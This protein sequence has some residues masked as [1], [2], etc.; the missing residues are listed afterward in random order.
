[1]NK[2]TIKVIS[3]V[4]IIDL[5]LN[6]FV[7]PAQTALAANKTAD[8]QIVISYEDGTT[9]VIP[10]EPS[11]SPEPSEQPEEPLEP[12]PTIVPEPSTEPSQSPSE[13]PVVSGTPTEETIEWPV[14][15]ALQSLLDENGFLTDEA[16]SKL[17]LLPSEEE[18]YTEVTDNNDGSHTM[19]LFTEPIKF[20]NE[21][22]E[23]ELIDNS[24]VAV[25]PQVDTEHEYKNAASDVEVLLS[26]DLEEDNAIEM[27]LEDYSIA[28]KPLE[29]VKKD[30]ENKKD[31]NFVVADKS[32]KEST[33]ENKKEEK[34]DKKDKDKKDKGQTQE[35][36]KSEKVKDEVFDETKEYETIEYT[37]TFNENTDIQITPT[38]TGLKE[39]I[40]FNE[41]P[42]EKKFSYELKVEK[43]VPLL[44]ED[45]NLYFIDLEKGLLVA[46]MA[47][48]SMHDSKEEFSESYDIKVKLEQIDEN[49]YKYTLIPSRVFLESETTVYPVV[50]DPSVVATTGLIADS[51]TTSRYSNNNYVNDTDLKVGYGSDLYISRGLVRITS[52]PGQVWGNTIISAYYCAYQNYSG[53]STPTIQLAKITNDWDPNNVRWNNQPGVG[54]VYSELN[55]TGIQWYT[56]DVTSLV[57]S[58]YAD[59][60]NNFGMYVK[61]SNEGS[62]KYKRFSSDNNP[63]NK[64][65]FVINYEDFSPPPTPSNFRVE[66]YSYPS[67]TGSIT[68][69]WSPVADNG[70]AGVHHYQT[71]IWYNGSWSYPDAYTT[72]YTYNNCP[73]NSTYHFAVRAIDT[74][75]NIAENWAYVWNFVSP[76]KTGPSAPSGFSISV[77]NPVNVNGVIWTNDT[78]PTINWSGFWDE[79]NHFDRVEY[80]INNGEWKNKG[81]HAVAGSFSIN[82][83]ELSS[84]G[85]YLIRVRGMDTS[86]NQGTPSGYLEYNKD[87]T[88]PSAELILGAGNLNGIESV[89]ANITDGTGSG[90]ANWVLDYGEGNPAIIYDPN[91]VL[92]SSNT[93]VNGKIFEWDTTQLE[94]NKNYTLRLRAYDK[95]GNPNSATP[96]PIQIR[97]K[98]TGSE[99]VSPQLQIDQPMGFGSDGYQPDIDDID[100][101]MIASPFTEVLFQKLNDGGKEGLDPGKLYVNNKLHDTEAPND[102]LSFNAA[103]YENGKWVYP[104]GSIVFMYTQAKD[105]QN[106]ELYSTGTQIALQIADKFENADKID[107]S[108]IN[109]VECINNDYY[110]LAKTNGIFDSSGSFESIKKQ[111][112][113]DISYIDLT[114][115][116]TVPTGA[117]V[118][119]QV[120]VDGGL[121][122]QAISPVSTDGGIT[123]ILANRKYFVTDPV[124]D[125]VKIK[126]LLTKSASNQSPTISSWSI[127]VRYTTYAN[128]LLIDNSFPK[129]A[130]GMTN[131][132]NTFHNEDI[133]CIELAGNLPEGTIG[134]VYSTVRVTSNDVTKACLEVEQNVPEGTGIS[135]YISTQGGA[136]NTW[137]ELAPN[138]QWTN[139]TNSG[140]E[141]VLA[142]RLTGSGTNSPQLL[143]WKLG[144]EEK[145]AGSP[146]MVKL[147]DEPWNLSTLTDVT[148]RTLL[149]WEASTTEGVTYNVYRSA[150][151]Y[152]VPSDE[153]KVAEGITET[154]W[155][156]PYVDFDDDPYGKTF[157]YK[158][159]AVKMIGDTGNEHA[160]ESLPSNEERAIV[161]DKDEIEKYLGLQNYWSYTGFSTGSGTG[162]VNVANGNMSYITTDIVVSDPFFATVMRRTFNSIATTKT[163]LGYSWDFSFNTCLLRENNSDGSLKAMILKD[164]DGSFHYFAYENGS[165][166]SAK[167][168][169]M[170]LTLNEGLKEYQIKRKDNIVY[171]FDA[172]SLKLKSFSDNNGNQLMFTY[173]VRGNLV[174]VENTVGEKVELTY[175]VL[176]E[177]PEDPDYT[178]ENADYVYVNWHPDL[179][180]TVTWTESG[181]DD[182]VSITYH[183]DYNDDND[184]LQR[185]YTTVEQNTTYEEVFSY[186]AAGQL[187]AI[188]DPEDRVTG[189]SYGAGD[190]IASIT[191]ASGE[192]YNYTYTLNGD[193]KPVSTSVTNPKNVSISYSYDAD[194]LV[195]TK[196]DALGHSINYTYGHT[197]DDD[198][199]VT[200][201]S[202]LNS[203]NGGAPQTISYSYSYVNG[204][205][206]SITAPDGTV[207]D[208][209]TYNSFNKPASVTVSKGSDSAT[210]NYSYDTAGN[211]TVSTDPEDKETINTYGTVNGHA[212]YLTQVQGDFGKQT[213]Y[214]Y[215]TKGRVTEVKEYDNGTFKR[216]AA[217]YDYDY[218]PDY[219]ADGY[220]MS[221]VTTDAMGNSVSSYYDMLGRTVKKVYPDNPDNTADPDVYER[222]SYD[223]VGNVTWMRDS[224]GFETYYHYD[225]MYRMTQ[226]DYADGSHN[227]VNYTGKWNSDG[228]ATTGDSNGNDADRIV[229]TDGTGLQSIEYYDMAG[230]LVKTSVSGASGELV[231]ATYQYDSIGNCT[232]VT[233]SAGRVSQAQYNVVGQKTKTIVDPTG[234]N[235]QTTYLYDFLGNQ[236]SVTDGE[237]NTTSYDYDNDSRLKSVTQTL[238]GNALTTSY[239]YDTPE[240]GVIKNRVTNANGQVSETWFDNMGRK[241]KDYNIGNTGD[242]TVMQTSYTYN[243]NNQPDIVTRNDST[244]EKYT[245]NAFGNVKR[246]DYYEAAESTTGNSDDFVEYKYNNSG[247]VTEESVTRA[248][249]THVTVYVYDSMGRLRQMRQGT[250]DGTLT[251]NYLYD[252]AGK[253]R[254]ISYTK[255][256]QARTL[257]Y[258]YDNFGRLQYIKLAL[259]TM[260]TSS[261]EVLSTA[262]T[263]RE[264]VYKTNGDLDYTKDFRNFAGTDVNVDLTAYI[265]TAYTM[266][267]AGLATGIT[268]TDYTSAND[269][270][271]TVKEQYT[272]GYDDRGFVTSEIAVTNYGTSQTVNKSYQYDA[273]GRL[274]QAT[275]GNKTNTYTYDNIGNR[276]SMNDG[277]DTLNYTYDTT[278]FNR[279]MGI[280]KGADEYITYAYD[281]RG[282]QTDESQKYFEITKNGRTTPYYKTTKYNYDLSNQLA[283]LTV[284]TPTATQ[285]GVV[286]YQKEA[287]ENA[288]NASGQRIVR[289]VGD[290]V[291]SNSNNV[292]DAGELQNGTGTKYYYTGSE[293]LYTTDAYNFMR[294]E[295][296]LDLGG[297]IIASKRFEDQDPLT[298]DPYKDNYYFY[299]YDKRGSTTAILQPDGTLI[300]GYTYDE[301]GNLAQ[302]GAGSFLNEVTFTGSITDT[303]SGL[304]YM[305]ARFYQPST[306]R[307]LSQDSYTGNP[308]DPWTQHLYS[309]C[310][311][312]PTNMIDPTGHNA[313]SIALKAFDG[314][315]ALLEAFGVVSAGVTTASIAKDIGKKIMDSLPYDYN[316][317]YSPEPGYRPQESAAVSSSTTSSV[318]DGAIDIPGDLPRRWERPKASAKPIEGTKATPI[319][320]AVTK[321]NERPKVP[322]IAY[323]A[324]SPIDR[325]NLA[326]T[327][328]IL[329]GNING[330]ASLAD[331]IAYGSST[332]VKN[333]SPWVSSTRRM[334]L[335]MGKYNSG[336][337]VVAIDLNKVP[338]LS[339]DAW[340]FGFDTSTHSGIRARNFS[341]YDM[342]V[343][344]FGPIPESA[345]VGWLEP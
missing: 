128:A 65:Y 154:S 149:R 285:A 204:N 100:Q 245:Y 18:K 14:D 287:T 251:I 254:Y 4:L 85:R 315:L 183:Y 179:L 39:D 123:Q 119:Y 127:D 207:R 64:N 233:D 79:G 16:L 130:R 82:D 305:N 168:T 38:S 214:T 211:L 145:L 344:T 210:T 87:T 247:K 92:K 126:A 43:V 267:N 208:Y 192:S 277:T 288:Y 306:G 319:A 206:D 15:I 238:A 134:W 10:S 250:D 110:Q 150:T 335:A 67:D 229:K 313:V 334:D 52:L 155:Y 19:K 167:G 148:H 345:I 311:N 158:V 260:P 219:D 300:K 184:K 326:T 273:I 193:G 2:S 182:P 278:G 143:S 73:D 3:L 331:H 20:E 84:D 227:S 269:A 58:W 263:V 9:D 188:S 221:V 261:D 105:S 249:V 259:G 8:N 262:K 201:M 151:P 139:V 141:I 321:E 46:A 98:A 317:E 185:A 68:L 187:I 173:D 232:Q 281:A 291:D 258:E 86:G 125:S 83:P 28:F 66:S 95:V 303:S 314:I 272:M 70:Y 301:F 226:A 99:Y 120:S 264:Y 21:K 325:D 91:N 209:G 230:R 63:S 189:I 34:K 217:T 166:K 246:V 78:T 48:P 121:T 6:V 242:S 27:N 275:I 296:I 49:T 25:D 164:G 137:Q 175:R 327:G 248:G 255:D 322:N 294:T 195:T 24:I 170:A 237:N 324:L 342:E 93:A 181:T 57:N 295:N 234:E 122:W 112:A 107:S 106:G 196:T 50:L 203:V 103:A 89:A 131:L 299:H 186:N 153:L 318:I 244:K 292:F 265:K 133:G 190:R 216:T 114:V 144:V 37:Q 75:G 330:T 333:N 339:I 304:Q 172:E 117:S 7:Y 197:A 223:L 256:S 297:S 286:S 213:R 341:R 135:Y 146:Y 22:G 178:P 276:L 71:A 343:C 340:L 280:T 60:N 40:V 74:R 329:P 32:N 152:F 69:T 111:F 55:V 212:G 157:Y 159:T 241:V 129:N 36:E 252:N 165:F 44:R 282:N 42:K 191:D 290:W 293:I 161:A 243:A 116:Q 124:G 224:S 215:D 218:N 283:S 307:F 76:D 30:K 132:V 310:G 102:G 29:I 266:N 113:G 220:F 104:E 17:Q 253:V 45:G 228:N 81:L 109:H 136:V 108:K 298:Y 72:S 171:H 200:G 162:Y 338:S 231:T 101:Y 312:N 199:L 271:G 94:D 26:D 202:Y 177:T 320:D 97:F 11:E 31:L 235:I 222:W 77:D 163:P 337:G 142:A 41:L 225:N 194:G 61:S 147:V 96:P 198:F 160:R 80:Q 138:A 12:T 176:G 62:N 328:M 1:M 323:R 274:T 23:Y 53:S 90:V 59:P 5:A 268:Y 180:D 279:L 54:A 240:D 205:L 336:N 236:A 309:Y 257:D 51:F 33:K 302:S 118:T 174:S 270:T 284:S 316:I 13:T 169:F 308:Y 239:L 115:D 156:D 56:W 332:S 35:E 88:G 47:A 140:K 289:T